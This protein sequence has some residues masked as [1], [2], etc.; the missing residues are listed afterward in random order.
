MWENLSLWDGTP[1]SLL[2]QSNP[3]IEGGA[4]TNLADYAK[5]L[6][7]HLNDGYCGRDSGPQ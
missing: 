3:N 1:D 5:L 4:I 2:G 6:Q 7:V